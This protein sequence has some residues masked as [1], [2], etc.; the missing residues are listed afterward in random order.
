MK[1]VESLIM[2]PSETAHAYAP[3]EA[4]KLYKRSIETCAPIEGLQDL[5]SRLMTSLD[6]EV[7]EQ[8]KDGKWRLVDK[9]AY[10]FD[11]KHYAKRDLDL[12]PLALNIAE[13]PKRVVGLGIGVMSRYRKHPLR[14]K[15]CSHGPKD[16]V[17]TKVSATYSGL[18]DCKHS[19]HDDDTDVWINV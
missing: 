4:V 12:S 8:I 17:E 7:V 15:E 3:D 1:F 14:D 6:F 16:A 2:S 5:R 11:W 9:A 10:S 18:L 13:T 19:V